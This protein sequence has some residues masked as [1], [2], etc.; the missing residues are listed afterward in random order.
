MQSNYVLHAFPAHPRRAIPPSLGVRLVQ[1]QVP[2]YRVEQPSSAGVEPH[3][4][5]TDERAEDAVDEVLV[6]AVFGE[7]GGEEFGADDF[8]DPVPVWMGRS[9]SSFGF[10]GCLLRHAAYYVCDTTIERPGSTERLRSMLS[11]RVK[12]P[13]KN[14][15]ILLQW[16]T[17]S[18]FSFVIIWACRF[19][20]TPLLVKRTQ[21]V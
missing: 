1:Q 6:R 12:C 10:Q 18:K 15:E 16:V 4:M 14:T 11:V 7:E 9:V 2:E 19:S 21:A 13:Y 5:A 3:A 8:G 17:N 20:T